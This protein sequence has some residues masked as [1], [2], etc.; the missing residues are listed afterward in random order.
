MSIKIKENVQ[1]RS[2]IFQFLS[3]FNIVGKNQR[4]RGHVKI[5]VAHTC[6]GK[7]LK[8]IKI[9]FFFFKFEISTIII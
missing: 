2:C 7:K 8:E 1:L 9:V 4:N 3:E 6:L 5:D